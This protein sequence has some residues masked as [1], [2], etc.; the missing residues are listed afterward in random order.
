MN[1]KN[2]SSARARKIQPFVVEFIKFSSA[3]VAIIA[4][5]LLILRAVGTAL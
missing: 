2:S 1:G 3:F 5:G 4:V